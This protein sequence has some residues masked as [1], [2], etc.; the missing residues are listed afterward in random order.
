VVSRGSTLIVF[1]ALIIL[2][3]KFFPHDSA[4]LVVGESL[5]NST[6]FGMTLDMFLIRRNL[7]IHRRNYL[8]FL[9][10]FTFIAKNMGRGLSIFVGGLSANLLRYILQFGASPE[11]QAAYSL[12]ATTS[13]VGILFIQSILYPLF[14]R[15][16]TAV[17]DGDR[18][19]VMNFA[20]FS[21]LLAVSVS[22]PF[23]IGWIVAVDTGLVQAFNKDIL[24]AITPLQGTII[25]LSTAA[26][27]LRVIAWNFANIALGQRRQL[28]VG[29]GALV[30]MAAIGAVMVHLAGAN[31]AAFT[32]SLIGTGVAIVVFL[33]ML[34]GKRPA[35]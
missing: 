29:T 22:A 10:L 1:A 24:H 7:D 30:L 5:V 14:P 32:D 12:L 34:P 27:N 35:G 13:R 33:S 6:L 2:H 11:I 25:L 31:G 15:V 28:V 9:F 19:R 8:D 26:F 21:L 20:R 23:V 16:R 17:F 18:R 3:R 4:S